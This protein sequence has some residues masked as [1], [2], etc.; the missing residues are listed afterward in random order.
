MARRPIEGLITD[1]T[2]QSK[3]L[4]EDIPLLIYTPPNFTPLKSYDLLICQDGHDYFQIGRI[5]RVVE[6][7]IDEAE[8]RE[9][10]IVGVPY[11]SVQERRKRYHPDGEKMPAYIRFLTN[12]L[13]P[14]IDEHYPTHELA[15]GRTLAGDSLAATVS[16]MAAL[17]Y[18]NLFGQ[19]M[20]HSPYVDDK[21]LAAIAECKQPEALSLY[22]VIGIHETAVDT[23]DGKTLD[24][25]EPNRKMNEHLSKLPFTYTYDEFD[26]DHTWKYWQKDLQRGLT[27]LIPF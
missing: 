23:T 22:H 12:E 11:P 9:T 24:F 21:V 25:V 5:P 10:I 2:I 27:T 15:S 16:L 14:Y 1:A 4:N 6:A 20:M 18:P 13:V 8:I 3:E 26:G 7:L 17:K 19:V